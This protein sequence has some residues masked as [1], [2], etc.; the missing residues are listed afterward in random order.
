MAWASAWGR[1]A[2]SWALALACVAILLAAPM[3]AHAA[4][5]PAHGLRATYF[6]DVAMKH[7]ALQRTDARVDFDWRAGSPAKRIGRDTFAARWTGT[8]VAPRAGRYTLYVRANDGARLTVDGK[9]RVNRWKA[10]RVARQNT[11]TMT[12]G[13]GAHAI[14]LD[15]FDRGGPASVQLAW[16]GPRIARQVIPPARL[17]PTTPRTTTETP[18]PPAEYWSDPKTWG[19][20]VPG[21][22][23][24]V[25]VPAGH[26][27]VLDQDA[28]VRD[29]TVMG[30]LEFARRDLTLTSDWIMVHD[31]TLRV[32]TEASPFTDRAIIRL[33]DN[34]P[35][36]DVMN[37]GDKFIGV[38]GGTLDLHG[39]HRDPWTRLAATAAKGADRITLASK[40]DWRVG[41]RIAISS[42]D[43]EVDQAEEAT[44]TAINGSSVTLDH[45]LT[46]PHY[47]QL[48]QIAGRT[49]DER[50]EVALLNRT[51][52]VEGESVSSADGFG[53]QIMVMNGARARIEG[54]ELQRVGQAGLL[55][56]YPL[57]FHMLGDGGKG[58]YLKDSSVHQSNNRCTTIHGTNY[59]AVQDNSCF[60]AKG[61]G[62]FFEDGAEHDNVVTGN[63]IFATRA[64]AD[65]KRI[66]PSDSS[67][68]SYWI[69]NPDNVIRGNVAGGSDGFGFWLAFPEHPTGLFAIL[70]PALDAATW[71]RRTAL[72]E[73]ASNTTHSNGRDGLHL[74]NGPRSDGTTEAT[75]YSAHADPA[76]DD[77]DEL[78]TTMRGLVSY[79][80]RDHGA[81]LRGANQRLVESTLAD[82]AIGATFA[83]DESMLQDSFVVGESA[84]TGTAEKWEITRGQVGPGGRSLPQPWDADFPLRGFEFY[85][86]RVGV[87]RTTFANFNPYTDGSGATRQ[88]SALGYH[89]DDDFSIH[90]RNFVTAVSFVNAKPV[91]LEAP[92][93]GHDGD[94]SAVFL[95]TD[96]SLTGAAGRSVTTTN[97]FLYGSACTARAD[98]NAMTC[99]GDYASLIVGAPG[100][101]TAVHPVT[102]TRA[103]GAVQML[104]SSGDGDDDDGDSANSTV[105][106][107]DTY[108]VAFTGGTPAKTRFV[109][110]NGRDKWVR[111]AVP[112]SSTFAVMRYGCN[113]GQVGKWCYS[114]VAG[115][116]ALAAATKTSWYYDDAGDADPATGTIHIKLVSTNT[117]WDE[118]VVQ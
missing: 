105:L 19:G 35:G 30:I 81:W 54:V 104:V 118:M 10:S 87:E 11:A 88:E 77:S 74:D 57:H 37:M 67:P 111:V 97:P 114:K 1:F 42:T 6:N 85:D 99:N 95:D 61:H 4:A 26:R 28:A 51:I 86:G 49:L 98:W 38:M 107:G 69:T 3:T 117:D 22:G 100:T 64:P 78:V 16:K 13:A 31:G 7:R 12:L 45:A 90:P 58:S 71:P 62:I 34:V 53:A 80:N 52:T 106:V 33:R 14:Q 41:D 116:A 84:N 91:F 60:D 8:L 24:S 89:L 94:V 40:P 50:A 102:L 55:R 108:R 110:Y 5:A 96:G 83:N 68:A 76:D 70:N 73:F 79:K 75:Y 21:S 56:R 113:A 17:R 92:E 36:E 43:F 112:H 39:P 65:D 15:F 59:V 103:D 82:N 72:G 18:D 2:G 109:L 66:L 63:L 32:G 46:Y 25:T 9:R 101:P 23:D 115:E 29:V 48:Q 20:A 27:I 44:I 93:S 47:G